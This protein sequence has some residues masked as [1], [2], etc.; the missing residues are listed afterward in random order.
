M[1]RC[2]WGWCSVD[3]GSM[4]PVRFFFR[5]LRKALTK[6]VSDVTKT[7]NEQFDIVAHPPHDFFRDAE[8]LLIDLR[9]IDTFLHGQQ[10]IVDFLMVAF[11]VTIKQSSHVDSST[12]TSRT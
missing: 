7:R 10:F 8:C 5:T 12:S 11:L 2:F 9:F 4:F 6:V 3:R 1:L